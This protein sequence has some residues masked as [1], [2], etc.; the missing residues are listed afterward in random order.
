MRIYQSGILKEP[1]QAIN[2]GTLTYKYANDGDDAL[3]AYS[4]TQNVLQSLM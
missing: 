4:T 3:E 2:G 1:T